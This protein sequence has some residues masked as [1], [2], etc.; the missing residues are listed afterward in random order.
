MEEQIRRDRLGRR[1]PGAC[2]G[3]RKQGKR[4]RRSRPDTAA[5]L[6]ALTREARRRRMTYGALRQL[7]TEEECAALLEAWQAEHR[8]RAAEACRDC[9]YWRDL[10]AT[11]PESGKACH[12]LLDR[13]QRRRREG[14]RCLEYEAAAAAAPSRRSAWL[15]RRFQP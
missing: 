9:V 1:Y 15:G 3:G 2:P 12:F 10:S 13:G 8:A 11:S 14:G 4:L 6:S 7:L 5:A